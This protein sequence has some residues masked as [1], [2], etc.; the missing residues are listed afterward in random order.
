[1]S[2]GAGSASAKWAAPPPPA[3]VSGQSF[4]AYGLNWLAAFAKAHNKEAGLPEFGLFSTDTSG[5]G[6][7]AAAYIT[8][9]SNWIKANGTG[10]TVFWNFGDGNPSTGRPE[11]HR[12]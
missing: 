3:A 7:D 5:G 9:I 11:L 1:L 12:R 4:T 8:Q 6:G 10:P 2:N